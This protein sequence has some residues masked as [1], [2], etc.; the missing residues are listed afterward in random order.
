MNEAETGSG[1]KDRNWTSPVFESAKAEKDSEAGKSSEK[2]PFSET[3]AKPEIRN[4]SGKIAERYSGTP[5]AKIS[6]TSR[7]KAF[8]DSEEDSLN[9]I[10]SAGNQQNQQDLP[11]E[12]EEIDDYLKDILSSLETENEAEETHLPE[13]EEINDNGN[14]SLL[15]DYLKENESAK[16]ETLSLDPGI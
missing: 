16:L 3:Q 7:Y 13:S 4:F 11:T 12:K 6:D 1:F 2:F 9:K 8:H 14:G 15:R 5:R 10:L